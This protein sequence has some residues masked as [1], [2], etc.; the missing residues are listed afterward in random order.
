MRLL[1]PFTGDPARLASAVDFA[2]TGDD[3]RGVKAELAPP[4]PDPTLPAAPGQARDPSKDR[5]TSTSGT[6]RAR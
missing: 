3:A 6:S 4:G 2:T 5:P 1:Q